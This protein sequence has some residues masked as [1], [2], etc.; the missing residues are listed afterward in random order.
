M[1][2]MPVRKPF[3]LSVKSIVFRS[4]AECLLLRRPLDSKTNPGKWEFPG[5]KAELGEAFEAAAQREV[6]E[7][8]GLSILLVRVAGAAEYELPGIK[9]AYIIMEGQSDVGDVRLSREHIDFAWVHPEEILS[10]D[11]AEQFIPFVRSYL[12]AGS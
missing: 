8:T 2:D 1:H 6:L 11:L 5:G 3:A 10:F 9:V 12:A 4:P 7:E